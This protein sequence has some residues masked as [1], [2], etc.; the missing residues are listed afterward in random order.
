MVGVDRFTAIVDPDQ[1]AILAA[2]A[3]VERPGATAA[4]VGLVPQLELTLT[5]DHRAVDGVVAGRFLVAVRSLLEG[6]EI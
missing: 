2:G 3:V 1:T 5:A 6:G 4:G